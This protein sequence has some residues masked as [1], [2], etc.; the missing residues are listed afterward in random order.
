M[1]KGTQFS[2]TSISST[3]GSKG[4]S[5]E[6][7][8]RKLCKSFPEPLWLRF[9]SRKFCLRQQNSENYSVF[10]K[11]PINDKFCLLRKRREI[12]GNQFVCVGEA[13]FESVTFWIVFF[14]RI[15]KQSSSKILHR[16][17]RLLWLKLILS[18]LSEFF[19]IRAKSKSLRSSTRNRGSWC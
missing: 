14:L 11:S 5:M 4:S 12:P 19:K 6:R 3:N 9:I 2:R 7:T 18:F 10:N 16:R 1:L 15:R 8:Q 13:V 17:Y